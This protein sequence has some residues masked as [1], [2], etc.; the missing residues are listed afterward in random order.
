MGSILPS[1]AITETAVV[2]TAQPTAITVVPSGDV[3]F[4]ESAINMVGRRQANGLQ[5]HFSVLPSA[6]PVGLTSDL[7]GNIWVACNHD[8]IRMTNRV[9]RKAQ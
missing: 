6:D 1:G 5:T 7:G 8:V 3:W 9:A 2:P 4:S